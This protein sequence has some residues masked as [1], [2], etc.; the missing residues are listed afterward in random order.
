MFTSQPFTTDPEPYIAYGD[1]SHG[2]FDD[3]LDALE[4]ARGDDDKIEHAPRPEYRDYS[5]ANPILV[6]ARQEYEEVGMCFMPAEWLFGLDTWDIYK[7]EAT[8]KE[9]KQPEAVLVIHRLVAGNEDPALPKATSE[10]LDHARRVFQ[11]WDDI[12]QAESN[13]IASNG[14]DY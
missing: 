5:K 9:F 3:Y 4:F 1:S 7:D 2:R 12:Q 11:K 13:E 6:A 14:L 8:A 10:H